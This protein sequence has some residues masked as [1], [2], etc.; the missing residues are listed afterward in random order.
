MALTSRRV[1]KHALLPLAL[2]GVALLATLASNTVGFHGLSSSGQIVEAASSSDLLLASSDAPP[3]AGQVAAAEPCTKSWAL[4]VDGLWTDPTKWNPAGAPALGDNVCIAVDGNYT[5]TLNGS[6]SV[7]SVAVGAAGNTA[8]QTLWV[9]GSNA[10][11]TGSLTVAG[12]ITNDGTIRMESIQSSH[13]VTLTVA[14]STITNNGTIDVNFGNSGARTISAHIDN[15]G[16]FNIKQPLTPNPPKDTDG[17]REESGRG[18]RELQG[19]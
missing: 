13:A 19:K 5:V 10:G 18:V 1:R 12:G 16:S 8:V 9:Q 2:A 17:R 7:N 4:A 3:I 11:G 14:T 6:Q 15:R